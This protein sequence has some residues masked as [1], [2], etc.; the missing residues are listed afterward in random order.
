MK[1]TSHQVILDTNVLM[2]ISEFH[3]DVFSALDYVLE[4]GYTVGVLKGTILELETIV[5]EQRGKFRLGAALALKILEQKKVKVLPSSGN[6]DDELVAASA[7]GVLVLTQDAALKKRLSK[8]YLTIR[9]KK[10]VLV[11][12]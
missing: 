12:V 3:L 11:V 10:S 6:V 4:Q 7:Q 5:H 2:A 1:P 8:P 9:A